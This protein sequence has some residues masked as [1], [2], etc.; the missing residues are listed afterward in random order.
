MTEK[1]KQNKDEEWY[2]IVMIVVV[3]LLII[4]TIGL[5]QFYSEEKEDESKPE[6][7]PNPIIE[8][9]DR[10]AFVKSEIARLRPMEE[11]LQKREF[12]VLLSARIILGVAIIILNSWYVYYYNIPFYLA[13]QVSLNS[14]M[15]L[16][17]TFVAFVRYGSLDKFKER[18]KMLLLN[19]SRRKHVDMKITLATLEKEEEQLIN[20]I[21]QLKAN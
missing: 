5:I 12:Y 10:L 21:E 8:K 4:L 13:K 9:E 11:R 2:N 16:G 7:K 14:A 3:V 19:T 6:Q 1:E 18:L 20:E 17:Y 15:V